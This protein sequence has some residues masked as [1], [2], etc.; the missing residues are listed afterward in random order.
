MSKLD[1][2]FSN[3]E[4]DLTFNG[5]ILNALSSSLSDHCPLLLTGTH[6]PARLRAL[7]FENYWIKMLGFHHAVNEAWSEEVPHTEPCH[8]LFHKL[9][10]LG[11]KLRK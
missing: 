6:S 8:V 3:N 4:W 2:V 11:L 1:Y 5:H 10:R 9:K 7:K